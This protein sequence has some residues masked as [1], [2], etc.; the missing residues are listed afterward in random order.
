M[1]AKAEWCWA[2]LKR[3]LQLKLQN[4]VVSLRTQ[5][6]K[7]KDFLRSPLFF[8]CTPRKWTLGKN[9]DFRRICLAFSYWRYY[10]MKICSFQC[11]RPKEKL[12]INFPSVLNT[13]LIASIQIMSPC[14]SSMLLRLKIGFQQKHRCIFLWVSD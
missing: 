13:K 9:L 10:S 8:G 2:T 12:R 6:Q 14:V 11:I 7:T 1:S 4:G 3:S 5:T